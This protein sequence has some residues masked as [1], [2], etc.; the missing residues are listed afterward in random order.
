MHITGLQNFSCTLTLIFTLKIQSEEENIF[1]IK[2]TQ[3][4]Q[5]NAPLP[6][7]HTHFL[8]AK[9][10]WKK[11]QQETN[12]NKKKLPTFE[13]FDP[14]LFFYSSSSYQH[15]LSGNCAKRSSWLHIPATITTSLKLLLSLFCEHWDTL[16]SIV[17]FNQIPIFNIIISWYMILSGENNSAHQFSKWFN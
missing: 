11:R 6:H 10:E 17:P 5:K 16:T 2:S 7:M 9:T 1:E 12:N 14:K 8:A 15:D 4:E 13:K 3:N